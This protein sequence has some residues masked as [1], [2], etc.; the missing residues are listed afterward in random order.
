MGALGCG[1][2][3]GCGQGGWA[4]EPAFLGMQAEAER[5]RGRR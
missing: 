4:L 5:E 1:G 3:C 2:L